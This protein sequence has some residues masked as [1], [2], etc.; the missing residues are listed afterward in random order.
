M[1]PKLT[2]TVRR[3]MAKILAASQT[4]APVVMDNEVVRA[5]QYINTVNT[6]WKTRRRDPKP[7]T[8]KRRR[9]PSRRS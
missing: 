8:P 1:R 2:S 9:A 4:P 5:A 6:S 3:G 7:R